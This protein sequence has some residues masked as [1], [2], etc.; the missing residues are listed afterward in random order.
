MGART[1]LPPLPLA[2]ASSSQPRESVPIGRPAAA[3]RFYWLEG[4]REGWFCSAAVDPAPHRVG[5]GAGEG[6]AALPRPWRAA[7]G[8]GTE[9]GRTPPRYGE[10]C[11][12]RSLAGTGPGGPHHHWSGGDGDPRVELGLEMEDAPS[13]G[14]LEMPGVRVVPRGAQVQDTRRMPWERQGPER[15][16][17][18]GVRRSSGVQGD[19]DAPR[20]QR[21]R[22]ALF[23]GTRFAAEPVRGLPG[24][25]A[26]LGPA[27]PVGLTPRAR[28]TSPR[29][30]VRCPRQGGFPGT[31]LP[32]PLRQV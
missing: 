25:A 7:G 5:C 9:R 22:G 26:G 8:E 30:V 19:G 2:A 14:G 6:D 12:P 29:A 3:W 32:V 16:Q 15:P 4:C 11:R 28:A 23:A 31:L 17:D 21:A 10:W 27:R 24:G 20:V 1:A 18:T 13:E